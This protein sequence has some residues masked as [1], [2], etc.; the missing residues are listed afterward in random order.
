MKIHN[1]LFSQDAGDGGGA[2]REPADG[3]GVP[4]LPT[5]TAD[6]NDM[7]VELDVDG[8]KQTVSLG[9]LRAGYQRAL[10][11]EQRLEE[12]AEERKQ[13]AGDLQL[14]KAVRQLKEP[15]SS[16]AAFRLIAREVWGASDEEIET[17][18]RA[19]AT[20]A[21]HLQPGA[22][23]GDAGSAGNAGNAGSPGGAGATDSQFLLT[24]EHMP[25]DV[26]EVLEGFKALG[27]KPGEF[28][29]KVRNYLEFAGS[30]HGATK[31]SQAVD[32]DPILS[33]YY[34]GKNDP[35]GKLRETL[36]Q[37]VFARVSAKVPL[38]A[39]ISE[40]LGERRS[41]VEAVAGVESRRHPGLPGLPPS[42]SAGGG[43]P[44]VPTERPTFKPGD[45]QSIEDF[46]K[47]TIAFD[48]TRERQAR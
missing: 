7:P 30:Q 47:D 14:A 6:N 22:D 41:L 48:L 3:Q 38:E 37:D 16:E 32:S 45:G 5:L 15:G 18:L 19:R 43:S 25:A 8:E 28:L 46:T 11:G 13:N 36:R 34:G 1:T 4:P 2:V 10:V 31:L 9:K 42:A 27:L 12:A 23:A 44:A 24:T 20:A 40:V 29:A 26:R 35:D 21:A 33:V 39:A 17:S